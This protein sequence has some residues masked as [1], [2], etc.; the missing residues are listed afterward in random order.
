[1]NEEFIVKY[2]QLP[3]ECEGMTVPQVTKYILNLYSLDA[4]LYGKNIKQAIRRK[5]KGTSP[6]KS[7]SPRKT[8]YSRADLQNAI[9]DD[10]FLRYIM[11][12]MGKNKLFLELRQETQKASGDYMK[13]LSSQTAENAGEIYSAT[14]KIEH[15]VLRN[16][17]Y[18]KIAAVADIFADLISFNE[19]LAVHDLYASMTK[20]EM[21]LTVQDI[22]AEKR[23]EDIKNYYDEAKKDELKKIL[24]NLPKPMDGFAWNKSKK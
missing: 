10:N 14:E 9:N 18:L 21:N 20:D 23:L 13:R 24:G 4:K 2:V 11:K 3:A 12:I 22:A 6:L 17:Q 19:E 1:M 8:V 5:L 7:S 15:I 16:L